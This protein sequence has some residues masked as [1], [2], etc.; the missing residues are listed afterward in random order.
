M[1]N[2]IEFCMPFL[3]LYW[4]AINVGETT[5]TTVPQP[6]SEN[7]VVLTPT[8]TSLDSH[9]DISISDWYQKEVLVIKNEEIMMQ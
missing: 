4:M 7:A 2:I 8:S 9:K 3:F 5:D 6:I 1:S